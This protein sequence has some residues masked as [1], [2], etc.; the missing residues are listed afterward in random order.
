M[1]SSVAGNERAKETLRLMLR[2]KRV[3]SALLFAGEDGIGKKLF[4]LELAKSLNCRQSVNNEACDVCSSCQRIVN[5]KIERQPKSGDDTE[6]KI[7]QSEHPDVG[8]VF[9]EKRLI[10]VKQIRELERETNFRPFEGNARVYLIEDAHKLNDASSNA[11]LKTLE[12][13][14]PTTHII[15]IAS[16]PASLLPTILSRC[17]MIRFAPLT[18]E[19]IEKFLVTNKK[20]A[21]EEARLVARLARGRLGLALS[22]NTDEYREQRTQMIEALQSIVGTSRGGQTTPNRAHLLRIAEDLIDAKR[23]DEYEPRLDVLETLIRDVWLLALDEKSTHIVNEDI[24]PQLLKISREIN[25]ARRLA[26]WITYIENLR[27]Q[28]AFN[29]NR[30]VATDALLLKMASA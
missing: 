5:F 21:G 27:A 9:T 11:L 7:W 4:A 19:E 23:K 30:K 28:L 24:R 3:P 17:Q 12:E 16:R 18:T 1:F 2:N 13:T 6:D 26:S 10:K 25:N 22:L 8:I 15:L 14:P 20:R 29:I